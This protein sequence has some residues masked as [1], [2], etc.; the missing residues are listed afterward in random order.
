M[1]LIKNTGKNAILELFLQYFKC[2]L[3]QWW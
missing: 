1:Y 3:F 2:N